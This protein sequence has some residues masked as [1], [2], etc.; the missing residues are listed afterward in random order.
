MDFTKKNV[1]IIMNPS[2]TNSGSGTELSPFNLAARTSTPRTLNTIFQREGTADYYFGPGLYLLNDIVLPPDTSIFGAGSHLTSF[3]QSAYVNTQPARAFMTMY[4]DIYRV[5][6]SKFSGF[7]LMLAKTG[8][9]GFASSGLQVFGDGILVEDVVVKNPRGDFALD[10]ESFPI[11]VSSRIPGKD[12]YRPL[13]VHGNS[14]RN[15]R[16]CDPTVIGVEKYSYVTGIVVDNP[17]TLPGEIVNC[18]VDGPVMQAFSGSSVRIENNVANGARAFYYHDTYTANGVTIQGNRGVEMELGV[19]VNLYKA[20]WR[21]ND[22]LV[23]G[24][25][26]EISPSAPGCFGVYINGVNRATITNNIFMAYIDTAYEGAANI[27]AMSEAD[28]SMV[29]LSGNRL[30]LPRMA[31]LTVMPS[32][33]THCKSPSRG[34]NWVVVNGVATP[35]YS[36]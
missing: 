18:F 2:S 26:F 21:C 16:V 11:F 27:I 32:A 35:I 31:K 19:N 13:V 7:T 1:F 30:V 22:L 12:S 23:T 29:Y 20:P 28:C 15:C 33:W 25:Y 4:P 5:T 6:T 36:A 34:D 8:P 3:V 24:N 10:R 14:V 9:S 17:P